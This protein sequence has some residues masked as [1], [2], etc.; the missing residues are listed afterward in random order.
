MPRIDQEPTLRL[1][2]SIIVPGVPT[3][4]WAVMLVASL[5]KL[6]LIA[7]SVWTLVYFPIA[8]ITDMI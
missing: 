4:I 8:V 6:S 1:S 2:K 3:I 5:G 7:Y